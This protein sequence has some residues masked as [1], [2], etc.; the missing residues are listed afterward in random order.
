MHLFTSGDQGLCSFANTCCR[1]VEARNS[2]SWLTY[3][4]LSDA[5]SDYATTIQGGSQSAPVCSAYNE[6]PR[7]KLASGR[8]FPPTKTRSE[9]GIPQLWSRIRDN[10]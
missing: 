2:L 1:A 6:L 5:L 7:L 10:P 3:T 9:L 8:M 4:A